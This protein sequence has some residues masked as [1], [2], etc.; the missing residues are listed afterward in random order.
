[1]VN[2]EEINEGNGGVMITSGL[3]IHQQLE[4]HKLFCKCPSILRNEEPDYRVMRKL[5][6]VAGET[7]KTDTAAKHEAGMDKT[8]YY[9]GYNDT[10]CLVELDEEP[11]RMINEEA[12]KI[13]IQISLL[14]NCEIIP[15]TQVM[16]KTVL[17]GSNT[18]GFQR[19]VMIGKNGWM[20]TDEG[21]VG[22][23]AVYLEEDAARTIKKEKDHK[24]FRL[25]RLGIPL[26]EVVTAPD[27]HSA[28][29]CKNVAMK[30]GEILR[31][32][33]VRRGIGTIRQDIN[34]SIPGHP[35]TE[36]KGFQDP[37]T[38]V[39]VVEKEVVRQKKELLEKKKEELIPEV[40]GANDDGT[41][42][43]LRPLPGSA[44]MYPETDIPIL[45]IS[46][47]MINEAKKT[48]PKMKSE[49]RK[50]LGEGGLDQEMIKLILNNNKL[51]EYKELMN[52]TK[53][54]NLVAKMLVLWPKEISTKENKSL[55]EVERILTID[56]LETIIQAVNDG[57]IKEGQ[58]RE[59]AMRVVEGKSIEEALIFENVEN[60]DEII[61]KIIKEKPGLTDN[62][63]MGL[64][65]KVLKG[66]ATGKE[67]VEA[68]GR[69]KK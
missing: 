19:T 68:I 45:R 6:L 65:M 50:E 66:K 64:A 14:L 13:A 33:K 29:Q 16:R 15:Y 49:L 1:M 43:Y 17:D 57:K 46:R 30:I 2:E 42:R 37:K 44:R 18:G 25:D 60:L 36:T 4:T 3:E 34:L 56:I 61:N 26:V 54:S 8:Y 48:L 38:F 23:W 5:H 35:R 21:R 12:V 27:I 10:T 20:E 58:A 62:A 32:S 51:E 63:Y 67:V 11:P 7:G 53:N 52:V 69:I 40:R 28:E 31:A 24:I 41:T 55:E 22:I 9:E 39:E 59:S 47:E